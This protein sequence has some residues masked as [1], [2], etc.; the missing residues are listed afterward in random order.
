VGGWDPHNVTEDA[1]LGLRLA[2]HGFDTATLDSRTYEEANTRLLN[3]IR[4]RARWLKGFLATWLV[5]MRQPGR[6]LAEVGP[7]GFWTAQAMT[8]GVFASALLH[9]LCIV[10]TILIY[11]AEPTLASDAGMALIGL[12]GLNLLILVAGYA[13]TMIIA[14]RALRQRGIAGWHVPIL[15]MP[16]YWLLMS[17]AAWYALWQFAVAPF[18]WNKTEHGLSYVQKR[19]R[20]SG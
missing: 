10:G 3:W 1:D 12:A 16:A 8:I 20:K 14:V 18:H 2:R 19:R 5:H 17:V 4:Q 11:L 9:P 7:A 13:V 6:L 15:T